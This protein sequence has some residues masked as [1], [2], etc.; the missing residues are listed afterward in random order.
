MTLLLSFT[1]AGFVY[2]DDEL[3][4]NGHDR[5][6]PFMQIAPSSPRCGFLLIIVYVNSW[7]A[8]RP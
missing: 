7:P 5:T 1:F 8:A 4:K 3:P 2:G 6:W